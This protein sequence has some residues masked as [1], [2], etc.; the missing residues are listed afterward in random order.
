MVTRLVTGVAD[1]TTA[2]ANATKLGYVFVPSGSYKV[3][4]AAISTNNCTIVGGGAANTN[5]TVGANNSVIFNVTAQRFKVSGINFIG[6][7]TTSASNNGVAILLAGAGECV[8]QDCSSTGF[9]FGFLSG[10]AASS[11]KG[12][13]IIRQKCRNTSALGNEINL[14]GIWTDTLIEDIDAQSANADR[15][16]LLYDN[17]TTGWQ[18]LIVRGGFSSGYK[19]QL[20]AVTDENVDGTNRVWTAVFDSVRCFGSNWSA[21]KAKTSRNIKVINCTFDGC[22]LAQEDQP[23]GLY[24]DVLVNSLGKVLI[25]GNTFR[26]SGSASIKCNAVAV[27]Q[28]PIANPAGLGEDLWG[29][30]D[31]EID[32][33]GVVFSATGY[34]IA[35]TNGWKEMLVSRNAMRN[36]TGSGIITL[37]AATSPFWDLGVF[38]NV[39]TD[40]P[41]ANNPISI[42]IGQS[43]RM[44]GNFVQN[45]GAT[46]IAITSV[47]EVS[48]GSENAVLD[49]AS[50]GGRGVQLNNC[51]N[52]VLRGRYGNSTYT[53][54]AITTAYSV[55]TRVFNGANVYECVVAGTSGAGAGP[56]ATSGADTSDGTVTWYFVGKYQ[57]MPNGV[58]VVGTQ[59]KVDIDVDCTGC[60]TGPFEALT[61]GT[62]GTTARFKTSLQTLGATP[63]NAYSVPLPD[64]TAWMVEHL[65]VAQAA[66]VPDRACYHRTGLYYRNGAGSVQQGLT[67]VVVIESNAAWD[68]KPAVTGN[69]VAGS[70]TGA[71]ATTVNW[72]ITA[73]FRSMP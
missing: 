55:G 35:V 34:G 24:G 22:G 12:P 29:I 33:T 31:N 8:T 3:T 48:M 30:Y 5:I 26:N 68:S 63:T 52:V 57:L 10:T 58:R 41:T 49:P 50:A 44:N 1:S 65:C 70:C 28:Y 21:I 37:N 38:D 69:N 15:V 16:L 39:I 45:C 42:S 62:G 19:K 61:T 72:N 46:G 9:G 60:T 20:W 71:A 23:N 54:W 59:V 53:Q 14:G 36:L 32:T 43:L 40:S 47:D 73:T 18:G 64:L 13:Q 2:F 27:V 66:A 11:L 17:N 7:G 6:D 25:Q 4:N 56:V 51:K 67:D